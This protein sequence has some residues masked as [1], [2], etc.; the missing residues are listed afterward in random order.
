MAHVIPEIIDQHV[1]EAAFL[2][3][4]R[5]GAVRA[6]HYLL[7][8]LA[9]LDNRAVAHLDGLRIAEEPGW[10]IMSLQ[11]AEIGEVGEVFAAGVIAFEGVERGR[12]D[13]V[14][15]VGLRKEEAVRGLV[16]ALGWLS[17]EMAA[18]HVKALLASDDP[19]RRRVGI[20]GAAVHRQVYRKELMAALVD[21]DP[22]LRARALRAVGELGLGELHQTV[23]KG[24][25]ADDEACRF[26]AAWSA[27]L[28]LG[29]KD[30]LAI[31]RSTAEGESPFA[32]RAL[33]VALRRMDGTLASAWHKKLA[34]DKKLARRAVVGAGV[35]GDPVRIRW[36]IEQMKVDE[37][38]RVAG[39]AFSM[40]TG[41]HISYDKL[42]A[43][44]PE[45]FES[46]PTENPEDENVAMDPDENL[47]WPDA[48][49]VGKWWDQHKGDFTAGTRY[50]VG[51]PIN[52]DS[53]QQVLRE[54]YQRQRIA[55]ALELAI[56]Q[57]GQPLFE[58]R[59]PG[60]RQQ[61]LLGPVNT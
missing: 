37:L 17:S 19:A 43:D 41:V 48:E 3:L 22:A 5:D 38:A 10:E 33:Q 1:E 13:E 24:F 14:L 30:G 52:V 42:E 21:R 59:A 40:I 39:E 8:D 57:P 58:V 35:I 6:P 49:L 16:S 4:L 27:A 44:K 45:G 46:G 26:W 31:L 60:H 18:K 53:L 61:K 56:R 54:G 34:G 7:A 15:G 32:D 50:L 11:L 20:A 36:L 29:D 12:I 9:E 55:A 2:W 47:Y 23:R 28:L 51:K 25:T